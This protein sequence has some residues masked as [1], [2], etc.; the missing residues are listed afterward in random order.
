[1]VGTAGVVCMAV[2]GFATLVWTAGVAAAATPVVTITPS[3]A[4]GAFGSGQTVTVSVGANSLFAPGT[5]MSII[6]CS[7]P[8]GTASNLPTSITSCDE[9]TIQG[10]TVLVQPGGSLSEHG[11]TLYALPN[12][13]LGEKA[14]WQPVC[15]TTHECV[16]YVGEDQNDFSRPKI[17]SPPF[18]FTSSGATAPT[19]SSSP[20]SP[21]SPSAAV[22]LPA[23]TLA[24]TGLSDTAMGMAAVGL[25]LLVVGITGRR[26]LR[27]SGR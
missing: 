24:F 5:R 4:K 21:S 7:D 11:Y 22:S 18:A 23:A 27:R 1:M 10:D 25:G 15:N 9:D 2:G 19:A 16:L 12:A 20:A 8:G 17:F 3:A 26:V 14:D 13:A 6:E